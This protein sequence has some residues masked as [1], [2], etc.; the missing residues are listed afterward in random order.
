MW[1][2]A[3]V[4]ALLCHLQLRVPCRWPYLEVCAAADQEAAGLAA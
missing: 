4:L 1:L 2:I 3:E